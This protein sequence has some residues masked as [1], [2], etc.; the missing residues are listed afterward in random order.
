VSDQ[1]SA[2]PRIALGELV[3]FLELSIR[4]A[5]KVCAGLRYDFGNPTDRFAVLLLYTTLDYGRAV[6]A[7]AKAG[8]FSGIPVIARSALEAYADIANLCDYPDYWKHLLVV[9]ASKWK[10][11]LERASRGDNPALKALSEDALLPV[12][13][14]HYSEELEHL[15]AEGVRPLKI[16]QRFERAGLKHEYESAYAMLSDETHS[17]VSGLQGHYVDWNENRAWIVPQ[18]ETS[19][20]SH[21]YELPGTLTTAEIVLKSTEKVL[22]LFGHGIAILSEATRELERIWAC[23]QTE[24]ARE[25]TKRSTAG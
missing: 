23:L 24:D 2:E 25:A 4:C 6:V 10:Q 5:V 16:W 18:G 14:R 11:L 1:S 15:S 21:H 20:H 8:T 13:L 12:G 17:N 3:A 19:K 22:R 7:L 9:D